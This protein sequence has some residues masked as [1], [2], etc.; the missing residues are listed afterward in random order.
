LSGRLFVPP[1]QGPESRGRLADCQLATLAGQGR[2]RHQGVRFWRSPS[3][4]LP[5]WLYLIRLSVPRQRTTTSRPNAARRPLR[6]SSDK[7]C[8]RNERN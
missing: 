6:L 8:Q 4:R 7:R 2:G 5:L 1:A 3:G